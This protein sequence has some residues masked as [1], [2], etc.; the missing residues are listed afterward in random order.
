M[1]HLT[2]C[3]KVLHHK[4]LQRPDLQLLRIQAH[5]SL[6]LTYNMRELYA[7]AI[8]HYEQAL[9][10]F[11]YVDNDEELAHIYYGLCDTYRKSGQLSKARLAGEK[12][13][14]LY[15]RTTSRSLE[16]R[17]RNQLGR[18]A[19]QEGNYQEASDYYT[20]AL[21]IAASLDSV[22]M[23]MVNCAA[24]ADL[25]LAEGRLEEAKRYSQR[26]KEVSN[27]SPNTFLCGLTYLVAGKVLMAEAG[28]VEGEQKRERLE[29]ALGQFEMA[30]SQLSLTDAYSELAETFVWRA[31]ASEALGRPQASLH[32]WKSAFQTLSTAKGFGWEEI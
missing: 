16:G 5:Y 3:L 18:I 20:E 30:H 31:Q 25:R 4:E 23:V 10:L 2:T 19:L 24:L 11:L 21:A 32:L 9:R 12:A 27:R 26:A 22:Q 15:E 28:E 17:M 8:Q 7:A 6:A 29:E 14:H 13:L 1:R